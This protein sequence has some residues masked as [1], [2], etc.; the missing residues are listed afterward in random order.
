MASLGSLTLDGDD[1]SY[2]T[3]VGFWLRSKC[4]FNV[5]DARQGDWQVELKQEHDAAVARCKSVLAPDEVVAHGRSAIEV[6]LDHV[7]FRLND[8][9]ELKAEPRDYV[10]LT[11]EGDGRVLT[12]YSTAPFDVRVGPIGVRVFDK[13][14]NEKLPEK[15]EPIWMPVLRYYRLS[16]TREDIFDAY[17]YMFLAFEALLQ[18][19]W[20]IQARER[21]SDWL[22][23]AVG[24]LAKR[25]NLAPYATPGAIDVV[26]DFVRSQYSSVR[27]PLFHSKRSSLTLPHEGLEEKTV[28]IAYSS[29][30]RLCRDAL[31]EFFKLGGQ[32]GVVTNFAFQRGLTGL[33]EEMPEFVCSEDP[34]AV[35]PAERTFTP[36]GFPVHRF[37]HLELE[38]PSNSGERSI[39]ATLPLDDELRRLN[40]RRVGLVNKGTPGVVGVIDNPLS[41]ARVDKFRCVIAFKFINRNTPRGT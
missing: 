3:A 39:I 30:T 41:L 4:S 14:G 40:V 32:S 17:R 22:E 24:E 9:L 26:N 7:C 12:Y 19:L 1:G 11:R 38:A 23:R 29:L 28:A 13:E 37:P 31:N 33:F 27:L 34:S 2:P 21:E 5:Q 18:S 36:R 15:T 20:P 35:D 16:Q 6:T 10:M 25:I 8:P